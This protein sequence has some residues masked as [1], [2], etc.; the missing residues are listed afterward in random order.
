[1][2]RSAVL[3]VRWQTLRFQ[4]VCSL[5]AQFRNRFTSGCSSRLHEESLAA[6]ATTIAPCLSSVAT[7]MFA[8]DQDVVEAA[9]VLTGSS[10]R[11]PVTI[12]LI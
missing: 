4:S 3:L 11:I 10:H 6:L 7:S 8:T 1:M 12:G 9:S 2:I 5:T